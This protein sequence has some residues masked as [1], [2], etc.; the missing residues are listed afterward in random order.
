MKGSA[1]IAKADG[2]MVKFAFDDIYTFS[3]G[4]I[5]STHFEGMITKK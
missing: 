4:K 2:R 1:W 5:D 3:N